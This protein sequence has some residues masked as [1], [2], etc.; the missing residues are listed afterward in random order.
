MVALVETDMCGVD[1]IQFLTGCT[2]G[3]GNLI[4]RDSGKNAYTFVR[5]S[6]GPQRSVGLPLEAWTRSRRTA[7]A[8]SPWIC[9]P[10]LLRLKPG[11]AC[12]ECGP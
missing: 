4:Q 11:P 5:R 1:A 12:W 3:K 8:W 2:L 10:E 7:V 6:A 9:L